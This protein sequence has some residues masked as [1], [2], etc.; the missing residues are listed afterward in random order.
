MD[1]SDSD[2]FKVS[3][4]FFFFFFKFKKKKK[5]NKEKKSTH[6]IYFSFTAFFKMMVLINAFR[7][8]VTHAVINIE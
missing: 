8:E 5:S 1:Q 6:L 7:I 2:L 4:P 3:L